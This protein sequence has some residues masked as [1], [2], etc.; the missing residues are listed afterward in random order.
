MIDPDQDDKTTARHLAITF[1]AFIAL[2][3]VLVI[4]ANIIAG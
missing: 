4:G 3:V 1:I 2:A